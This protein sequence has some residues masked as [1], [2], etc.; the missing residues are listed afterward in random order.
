LVAN[1]VLPHPPLAEK[2]VTSLPRGPRYGGVQAG[3]VALLDD[4]EDAGAQ[5][6]GEHR[7]VD[8]PADEDD[9]QAWPVDA[10]LLSQREGGGQIDAGAQNHAVLTELH[11]EVA[12]Q[13]VERWQHEAVRTERCMQRL[14]R[15]DV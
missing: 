14:G 5:C 8:A 11:V 7:G 9:G 13:R 4:L 15:P 1:V 6:V 3:Q 10:H 12:A 2:T